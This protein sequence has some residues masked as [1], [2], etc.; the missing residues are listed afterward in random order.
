M[1]L[2]GRA[3]KL[4]RANFLEAAERLGLRS[5]ATARMIDDID[6]AAQE[7]PDRCTEI[8]FSARQTEHLSDMLRSRLA[9]L[10]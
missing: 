8:G 2:Y 7:W 9:T 10:K 6:E 3:N 4:N 5:R 1:S